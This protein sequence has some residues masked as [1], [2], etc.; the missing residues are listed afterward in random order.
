[1]ENLDGKWIYQSFRPECGD[2]E[3]P[4]QIAVPWAGGGNFNGTTDPK[5]GI[6]SGT[7]AFGRGIELAISGSI[8]PAGG[9]GPRGV[10][11]KGEGHSSL[12]HIRGY[13][14]EGSPHPLIVGTVVA[15]HN[16]LAKQPDGT[17]G[18]FVL[19]KASSSAS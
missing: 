7:L 10:E 5:T 6:V 11:L 1:M 14:I 16:D 19:Y 3:M 4:A 12:N 2:G 18:P 8:T 15:V 17:S 13:F 9:H